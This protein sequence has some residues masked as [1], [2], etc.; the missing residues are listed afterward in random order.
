MI[1]MTHINKRMQELEDILSD[2]DYYREITNNSLLKELVI[3]QAA[4]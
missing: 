1:K 3:E 2:I 4:L